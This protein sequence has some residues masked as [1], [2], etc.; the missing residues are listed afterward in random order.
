M[1]GRVADLRDETAAL[2]AEF[3]PDAVDAGSVVE[4]FE[5]LDEIER[6]SAG[7]KIRPARRVDEVRHWKRVGYVSAPE[8]LAAKS[9]T[10]VGAARDVLATSNKVTELP[11]VEDALRAGRPSGAQAALVADASAVA[12]AAQSK[13]INVAQ[14]SSLRDSSQTPR[15]DGDGS[16]V[17]PPR[18]TH[19]EP[20]TPPC[21]R[22]FRVLR[23][24][25]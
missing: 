11:V 18:S 20:R 1:F 14:R 6:L 10:S 7:C 19:S 5:L 9:G 4:V 21:I 8:Y 15:I 2:A 12:P 23:T 13:L 25:G 22:H 24:A 16:A 17:A 3:D